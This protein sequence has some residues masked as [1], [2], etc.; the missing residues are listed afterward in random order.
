ME[1]TRARCALCALRHPF[2]GVR[3]GGKS[4][5]LLVLFGRTSLLAYLCAEVFN[6]VFAAFGRMFAPG[7]AH[8]FG[9]WAGP[10]AAW[11]ASTMLLVAVLRTR[12]DALKFR[13]GNR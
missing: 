12:Y 10:L 3:G 8:L 13:S 6:P 11:L 7:F 5:S 4:G 2:R 1:H 9:K